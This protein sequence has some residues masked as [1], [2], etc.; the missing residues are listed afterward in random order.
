MSLVGN[1]L[2]NR[3]RFTK[4]N[5]QITDI[6]FRRKTEILKNVKELNLQALP[7][8]CYNETKNVPR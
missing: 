4:D 1:V 6:M 8:A 7:A 3:F 2:S 5:G